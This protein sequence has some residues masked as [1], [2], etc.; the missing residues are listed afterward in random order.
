VPELLWANPRVV[1]F[2]EE[3]LPDPGVGP[4]GAQ[5]VPLT[6]GAAFGRGRPAGRAAGTPLWLDTTEPLSATPLRR[7]VMAQD[8]GSAIVGAVRVDLFFGWQ[9]GAEQPGRPHEAAAAAV[10]AVAQGGPA[11]DRR[12][13]NRS[14]WR[15]V[16]TLYF[17]QGL[18]Y[19]VVMTLA[20]VLYKNLG[21]DN[22]A[23]ALYT[24]WLYLPWVIKPLWSPLVDLLRTQ[25]LV[26]RALQLLV[27]AALAA[28]ALTLPLPRLLQLSL[29]LFWLLALP[30]PRTTSRPTASTCWP[31]RSTSRPPSWACAACSTAWR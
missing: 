1:F 29:A 8:T 5:G 17:G 15:W 13:V 7:L 2:R 6:P 4:R 30:R 3:P 14:P 22:T 26:D 28:V 16:P 24:S 11:A 9:P 31:C 10:G 12:T 19:V 20:V 27:G 25:A 21:L 23:I 18:P